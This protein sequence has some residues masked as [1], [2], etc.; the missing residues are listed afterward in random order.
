MF[1]N[2]PN[3]II[4][5]FTDITSKSE[6]ESLHYSQFNQPILLTKSNFYDE[7]TS[8]VS[9][10][11]SHFFIDNNGITEKCV[12]EDL[13]IFNHFS[14][15]AVH[16]YAYNKYNFM[17]PNDNVLNALYIKIFEL[18]Q[19]YSISSYNIMSEFQSKLYLNE[20]SYKNYTDGVIYYKNDILKAPD[21][22]FYQ[23]LNSTLISS[24]SD[25]TENK[26]SLTFNDI[27]VSNSLVQLKD[28]TLSGKIT[29]ISSDN[30][31]VYDLDVS[32]INNTTESNL[33]KIIEGRD[34]KITTVYTP[35]PPVPPIYTPTST[36]TLSQKISIAHTVPISLTGK[37][38]LKMKPVSDFNIAHVFTN[39]YS[40]RR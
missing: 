39:D 19:K 29:P 26:Y 11:Q 17:Q 23:I 14:N 37:C 38:Y 40:L 36:L 1:K 8:K 6:L 22:I 13:P 35:P 7:N 24:F 2:N 27:D 34:L 33:S 9:F 25:F 5:H 18:Q 16:I 21:N 3:F 15:N 10:I 32:T 20:F 30:I 12:P 31:F 28:V 4:V